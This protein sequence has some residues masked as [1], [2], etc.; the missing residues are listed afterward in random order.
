MAFERLIVLRNGCA[1]IKRRLIWAAAA[2]MAASCHVAVADPATLIGTN[3][4][5]P[6]NAPF[7]MIV[8]QAQGSVTIN[9]PAQGSS[10]ASSTTYPAIFDAQ[11]VTFVAANSWNYTMDRVSGLVTASQPGV[12]LHFSCQIGK[13]QF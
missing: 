2:L 4:Q 11:Q 9:N 7:T 10:P 6:A 5:Q 12:A 8:D 3:P 1:T 13:T